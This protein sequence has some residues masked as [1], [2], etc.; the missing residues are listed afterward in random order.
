[1]RIAS[2]VLAGLLVSVAVPSASFAQV[3][4][5]PVPAPNAVAR[6]DQIVPVA[7]VT[8]T[9]DPI[10]LGNAQ[11]GD[12]FVLGAAKFDLTDPSYP[13]I[14][15]TITNATGMPIALA[16]ISVDDVRVT[17]PPQGRPAFVCKAVA[18]SL[19]R[20]AKPGASIQP[21]AAVTAEIGTA[22]QCLPGQDTLAFLLSIRGDGTQFQQIEEKAL[23]AKAFEQLRAEAQH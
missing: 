21:G 6:L 20:W 9:G 10:G 7:T 1:M 15:F 3:F 16:N 13:R 18:F 2:P 11:V 22:P 14:A 4:N 5:I 17:A 12:G 8:R 19:G 23:L